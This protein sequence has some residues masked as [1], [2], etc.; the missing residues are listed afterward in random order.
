MKKQKYDFAGIVL[1]TICGLHCIITPIILIKFPE[2]GH[3]IESPWLQLAL[4]IMIAGI[5]YQAIYRNFKIHKSKLTLSLGVSGFVILVATY[6]NE[7]L[8]GHEEH[9][10][11]GGNE[12]LLS[13]TLAIIGSTL[14]ISS[15]ILNIKNCN[16][17]EKKI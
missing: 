17:S 3:K 1:S 13:I 2:L 8:M 14:M 11:H 10:R 7:L 12:E 15:H 9:H 16:C 5:F 4:L 6:I